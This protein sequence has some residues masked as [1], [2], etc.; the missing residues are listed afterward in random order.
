MKMINC[1]NCGSDIKVIDHKKRGI[2][3]ILFA[4]PVF[5]L[6]FVISKGT[7]APFIFFCMLIAIGIFFILKKDRYTYWCKK[8]VIKTDEFGKVL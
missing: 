2:L 1:N 3:S 7:I 4:I 6:T 5:C 8:C